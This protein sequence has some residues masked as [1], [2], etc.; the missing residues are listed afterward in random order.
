MFTRGPCRLDLLTLCS[1]T[2]N[3]FL[4]I[5]LQS[6]SRSGLVMPKRKRSSAAPTTATA[7]TASTPL[8]Q[9]LPPKGARRA[10]TRTQPAPATVDPN[11]NTNTAIEDAPGALRASPDSVRADEAQ[12]KKRKTKAATTPKQ[13]VKE[14]AD[15]SPFS[16]LEDV[17]SPSTAATPVA[18]STKANK[19]LTPPTSVA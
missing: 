15:E 19:K 3:P 6:R 17:E 1:S 8:T 13:H 10:S 7:D 12:P 16:E 18:R 11:P 4:A 14:E 5:L 2:R 9:P